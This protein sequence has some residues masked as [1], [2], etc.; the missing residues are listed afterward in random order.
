[1]VEDKTWTYSELAQIAE[2]EID[3]HIAEAALSH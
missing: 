1:M 2:R 3:V